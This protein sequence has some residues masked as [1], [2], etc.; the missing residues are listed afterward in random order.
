MQLFFS[1]AING[2][3]II[4]NEEE[5]KHCGKV[6]RKKNGDLIEVI[7]GKGNYYEAI[8][9][10]ENFKK[11][12]A[13]IQHNI[14]QW[15]VKPYKVAL[16]VAITKNVE[17]FDWLLEK[18]SEL[19][20]NHIIPLITERTETHKIKRERLEKILLSGIK[21]SGKALLPKLYAPIKFSN[22][23]QSVELFKEYEK[24]IAWCEADTSQHLKSLY[25][26]GKNALVVIGPEGDFTE[27]EIIMA[28]REN[29]KSV[30]LGNN[31]LR[32]ETAAMVACHI[33]HLC[34]EE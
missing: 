6:L 27:K 14:Q 19:G 32:V 23:I 10:D 3:T 1:D 22:F 11:V 4:L 28:Q 13:E 21:Q 17:R 30:S 16:A 18:I 31:R 12:V 2:N 33:V 26:S 34:N 15:Q 7:D 25:H 8:I 20:V 24:Y 5:S 9:T 29:F